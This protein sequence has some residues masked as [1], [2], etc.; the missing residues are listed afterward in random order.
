MAD[1]DLTDELS[2]RLRAASAARTPLRVVGG[3][4]KSFYGRGGD[5]A[6]P[7]RVDGHRG[8]LHYDPAEL[9]VTARAGTPLT[10]LEAALAARGQHLPFE[11]PHFGAGATLGGMVAS[12]LAGPARHAAGPV[13]DYVLGARILAGDGRVLK[14]GGEVMKN[15]AGY[16]V[17]RLMAGSLGILGVLLD[18]SLKVLPCAPGRR[19]LVLELPQAEALQRMATLARTGLPVT[20]SAWLD[21]RWHLRL[22]GSP[23]ALEAAAGQIGGRAL[24]DD[25]AF[26]RSLREHDGGF[27]A[28]APVLWRVN[29]PASTPPLAIEAPACVEWNGAQRWYGDVDAG[30][31]QALA[32]A[33]GGHVTCFRGAPAGAEVFAPL[34]PALLSLH[35][36]LKAV[37]DPAGILNPGR[38]YAGL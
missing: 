10:E 5:A 35:R 17:A 7:C 38:M 12:G 21:G 3:G 4:T 22:D 25:H 26:W 30:R 34:A 2:E 6:A 11:P 29:L 8:I 36:R 15:V 37:F 24:P 31:L 27:F 13:R 19:T 28:A 9:V 23:P 16:D 32:A 20:G 1:H 14:F 33:A 18:V